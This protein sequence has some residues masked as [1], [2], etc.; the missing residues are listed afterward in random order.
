[1]KPG[2]LQAQAEGSESV[3]LPGPITGPATADVS[4]RANRTE[5]WGGPGTRSS[6]CQAQDQIEKKGAGDG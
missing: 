1:M 2:K 3:G 5:V 6:R 4:R